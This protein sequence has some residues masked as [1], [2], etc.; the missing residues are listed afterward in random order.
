[1]AFYEEMYY[2]LPENERETFIK[3]LSEEDRNSL[4]L[5]LDKNSLY[6]TI[7]S[8]HKDRFESIYNE[9]KDEKSKKSFIAV[10]NYLDDNSKEKLLD[11]VFKKINNDKISE[12]YNSL[13]YISDML[14][15][16]SEKLNK[17]L[18]LRKFRRI[19]QFIIDIKIVEVLSS[20]S[21]I[22]YSDSRNSIL[23]IDSDPY[24]SDYDYYKNDNEKLLNMLY[25]F[26]E[27]KRIYFFE[28]FEKNN[29]F[30]NAEFVKMLRVI[31]NMDKEAFLY[32]FQN[33][34]ETDISNVNYEINNSILGNSIFGRSKER[35]KDIE[36]YL[37][38][39]R[40]NKITEIYKHINSKIEKFFFLRIFE[41]IIYSQ[42]KKI[43]NIFDN[44]NYDMQENVNRFSSKVV[45]EKLEDYI[46]LFSNGAVK[47]EINQKSEKTNT[48]INNNENT[49]IDN[50]IYIEYTNKCKD[51][52]IEISF[53][54]ED[55]EYAIKEDYK[56]LCEEIDF[57][58]GREIENKYEL[59]KIIENINNV[60]RSAY[61]KKHKK[62][63][64]GYIIGDDDDDID[65]I[66]FID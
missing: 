36:D 41:S 43:I 64:L 30:K 16:Y 49:N 23:Y 40:Y 32:I 15:Q 47:S 6:S 13:D 35:K 50:Y 54:I 46:N 31:L 19:L 11:I 63:H 45:L 44:L 4:M 53:L 7:S 17:L 57:S 38:N 3:T 37:D 1:M 18:D 28:E 65:Y 27:E 20:I 26:P 62:S 29:D 42:T 48:A 2:S 56:K 5:A 59:N 51:K 22:S 14:P 33:V 8:S 39:Y 24:K 60:Y 52:L 10:F 21:E 25:K 9:L 55:F 34:K 66:K 12:E 58:L 61:Y